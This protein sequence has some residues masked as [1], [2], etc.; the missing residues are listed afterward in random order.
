MD[1]QTDRHSV[2]SGGKVSS[3]QQLRHQLGLELVKA[4]PRLFLA[5]L[6]L[7]IV[8]WLRE[9]ITALM[10]RST[11]IGIG[12][13][14]IEAAQATLKTAK[15]K[16]SAEPSA[17]FSEAQ[18]QKLTELYGSLL[19]EAPAARVLWVDDNPANNIPLVDF[20]EF[21]GVEVV[22]ARSTPDALQRLEERSFEAVV[23]DYNRPI[24]PS[25]KLEAQDAH[26]GAGAQ[27]G[28]ALQRS[29]CGR[30]VLLFSSASTDDKPIPPGVRSATNNYYQLLLDLA[31]TIQ[32]PSQACYVDGLQDTN[33]A[34]PFNAE[35]D[36]LGLE[37][38]RHIEAP[39]AM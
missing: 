3:A 11:K 22:V 24:D 29:G 33:S 15:L 35:E 13:V 26:W 9:P 30:K 10:E 37:G 8:L 4:A 28:A 16:P 32:S 27:L 25:Q 39:N 21:M 17:H 7:V 38:E 2:E 31:Q 14:S 19:E 23:S 6:V 34:T 5:L 36:E 12:P 20:L 1:D 18:V